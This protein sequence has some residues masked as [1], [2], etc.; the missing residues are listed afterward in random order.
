MKAARSDDRLQPG[1]F[2]CETVFLDAGGVLV[3]PNWSRVSSVLGS[4]GIKVTVESLAAADPLARRQLDSSD[5]LIAQ[6][7][8][9]RGWRY[10]DLILA[11]VGVPPSAATECALASLREYHASENLWEYVPGFVP[12]AL[13]ELRRQGLRLV[14]VSNANGTLS[15]AFQRLGLAPLVDFIVDSSE[16]GV[17]KP[18]RRL[19]DA[20]LTRSG[21]RRT[22]TVHVGDFYHIDVIGARNAELAA[23]LVDQEDLYSSIDCPRIRSIAELPL[24][25]CRR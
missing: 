19:F 24:L 5:E 10:F 14:V 21:A 6:A 22:T 9:T 4:H 3:W 1:K 12:P 11:R 15:R 25:M 17:E 8:Q 23:V 20:A 7:D 18:D 16:V 13:V 2:T